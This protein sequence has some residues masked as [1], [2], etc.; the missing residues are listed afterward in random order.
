MKAAGLTTGQGG[1]ELIFTLEHDCSW[2]SPS[3][4]SFACV[5]GKL[6]VLRQFQLVTTSALEKQVTKTNK[7]KYLKDYKSQLNPGYV[8]ESKC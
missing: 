8:G 1:S 6:N 7:Q 4:P 3:S 2:Q 5:E